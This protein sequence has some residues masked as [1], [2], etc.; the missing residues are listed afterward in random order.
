MTDMTTHGRFRNPVEAVLVG[1]WEFL[2]RKKNIRPL[3]DSDRLDGLTCLITG[4]SS[5]VGYALALE[6]ARRGAR[7]ILAC[8]SGIPQVGEQ[9]KKLSGNEQVEMLH[10]DLADLR[11]VH[12]LAD[13]LRDRAEQLDIVH[14]NAGVTPPRARKTPQGLDEMFTVNYLSTFLL[15]NRLLKDGVIP[16][17]AFAANPKK[18]APRPRIIIT[19]SDSHRN[20]SAIDFGELGVYRDYGVRGSINNYSYFKLILN[21]FAT[22][23]S[24]RLKNGDEVDASVHTV[25][26]GPVNS[27]IIRDAPPILRSFMRFIFTFFF[28]TPTK[29]AP[30]LV[31]LACAPEI[32]GQT[33]LYLHMMA[34]KRMDEKV[35]DEAA[36]RRLW[37]RSE[38]LLEEV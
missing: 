20:A 33:N 17:A 23:L 15:L 4:A 8:R 6:L 25:C 37:I 1:V 27:N 2:R 21:T 36:G 24:G 32:E 34:Q 9:I 12:L 13:T 16:N 7:L 29:A 14:C 22:E 38:E 26:P 35:Y 18:G 31:Y 28:Q 19:S 10:V 3:Q 30:P 5:G 11:S